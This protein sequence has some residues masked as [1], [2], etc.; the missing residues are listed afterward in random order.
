[1]SM[2]EQG[3]ENRG[4]ES[5]IDP[6]EALKFTA[7]DPDLLAEIAQLFL[8]QGP[9]QLRAVKSCIEAGDSAGTSK[10]A[11]AL[12]GSVAIFGATETI[13]AAEELEIAAKAGDSAR[14]W[15]A[16][17]MLHREMEELLPE[18]QQLCGK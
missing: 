17:G 3:P 2:P 16:W 14:V 12:K 7:G 8:E 15:Q 13:E 1:M 6:I 4:T 18:V 11:H 5:I 10:A 9:K